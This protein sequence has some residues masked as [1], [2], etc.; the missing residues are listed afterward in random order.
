MSYLKSQCSTPPPVP[1]AI[2]TPTLR[3]SATHSPP[4]EP[5]PAPMPWGMSIP[6]P[7][8]AIMKMP[9]SMKLVGGLNKSPFPMTTILMMVRFPSQPLPLLPPRPAPQL[10]LPQ[11]PRPHQLPFTITPTAKPTTTQITKTIKI[12][13]T[14]T[15]PHQKPPLNHQPAS[16]AS[17]FA[18]PG[19]KSNS[20][21]SAT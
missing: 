4:S 18:L 5:M 14:T 15:S 6:V 1:M 13:Q 8:P 17:I 11:P 2:L 7:M 19:I 16:P 21:H 20:T 10:Q 12:T 3:N 9:Q